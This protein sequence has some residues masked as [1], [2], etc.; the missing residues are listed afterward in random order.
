MT[1]PIA[2]W[3]ICPDGVRE[4]HATPG[5]SSEEWIV[6]PL[7]GGRPETVPAA[8]VAHNETTALVL[9]HERNGHTAEVEELLV[10]IGVRS[11]RSRRQS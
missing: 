1:G 8:D 6:Q 5:A 4:V 11:R 7:A 10:R 9:Y 3:Q 2:L